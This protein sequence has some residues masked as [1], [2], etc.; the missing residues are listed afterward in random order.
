MPVDPKRAETIFNAALGIAPPDRSAFLAVACGADADLRARVERLLA[1][2][3]D[4]GDPA[5]AELPA[6]P[7]TAT[8]GDA[9]AT[10]DH[11][12][13]PRGCRKLRHALMNS[14]PSPFSNSSK[15]LGAIWAA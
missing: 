8:F 6:D 5:T 9:G 2:H 11:T 12:P 4:L 7:P 3:A 1:A 15:E 10:E 13:T 14:T